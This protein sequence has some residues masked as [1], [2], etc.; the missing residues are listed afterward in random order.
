MDFDKIRPAVEEISLSDEQAAKILD[1]CKAKRHKKRNVWIPVAA[2]VACAVIVFSPT[3]FIGMRGANSAADS[4]AEAD[5]ALFDTAENNYFYNDTENGKGFYTAQSAVQD[6]AET[7]FECAGFRRIYGIVPPEFARLADAEEYENWRISVNPSNGMAI[8]QF[9]EYFGISR[10]DF[11][12]ANSEYSVSFADGTTEEAF[13]ADIIYTFDK[14][15]ID[16][17]YSEKK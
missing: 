3:V 7:I 11:D 2:A 16:R 10:E 13:N 12:R 6:T 9:V 14:E 1:A 5:G 17:Y 15:I 4:A 8:V